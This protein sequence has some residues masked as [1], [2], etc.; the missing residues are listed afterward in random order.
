[1]MIGWRSK[2]NFSSKLMQNELKGFQFPQV[3]SD[4]RRM[5]GMVVMVNKVGYDQTVGALLEMQR[6][7]VRKE[8]FL[9][10]YDIEL[11]DTRIGGR[12]VEERFKN[13]YLLQIQ[14]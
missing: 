3:F 11:E 6:E 1:M 9:T 7:E 12:D 8:D 14:Y 5:I 4:E 10:T 13:A 2:K